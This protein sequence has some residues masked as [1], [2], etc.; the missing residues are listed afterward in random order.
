MATRG[1][2]RE[3]AGAKI[4]VLTYDR[5]GNRLICYS[6]GWVVCII[7]QLPPASAMLLSFICG[8][9]KQIALISFCFAREDKKGWSQSVSTSHEDKKG[10]FLS[11][12]RG[13]VGCIIMATAPCKCNVILSYD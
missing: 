10:Q 3:Y 8:S 12:N 2:L 5:F 11:H 6:R 9:Q 4:H 1:C 13:W 7:I